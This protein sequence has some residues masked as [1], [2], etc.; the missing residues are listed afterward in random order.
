M[1]E[2][3]YY[4]PEI[5]DI[6]VGYECEIYEQSTTKLI[7]DIK[8]HS[9]K[10]TIGN[11]EYGETLAINRVPNYLKQSKIR[12]SYLTKEQ[13]EKEGWKIQNVLIEDDD[14]NDMFCTGFVKDIDE[15]RWYELVFQEDKTFIQYK[16]YRNS[17]TQLCRPIFYGKIKSIN[18]FRTLC[19]WLGIC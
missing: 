12:T 18:E 9:V 14:G 4:I 16:W 1:E 15:N 5:E 10:V 7:K 2:L 17:V 6:K 11:S 13:I 3:K 19:K 8:W